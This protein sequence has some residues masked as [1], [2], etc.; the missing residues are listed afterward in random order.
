MDNY[1]PNTL[2]LDVHFKRFRM[3]KIDNNPLKTLK[4]KM[5]FKQFKFNKSYNRFLIKEIHIDLLYNKIIIKI[6]N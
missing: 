2:K 4:W 6:Y 3:N 1:P 5:H